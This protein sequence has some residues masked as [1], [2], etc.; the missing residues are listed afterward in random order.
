MFN[1]G[2]MMASKRNDDKDKTWLNTK[3][4]SEGPVSNIDMFKEN[5][6]STAGM[7]NYERDGMSIRDSLGSP[8]DSST[9]HQEISLERI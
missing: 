3:E 6:G 8:S 1:I 4:H 2:K 9:S 5:I 7:N